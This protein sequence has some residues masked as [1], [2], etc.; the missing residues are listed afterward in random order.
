MERRRVSLGR[1]AFDAFVGAF[2]WLM[3]VMWSGIFVWIFGYSPSTGK[4]IGGLLTL[5]AL[6][7]LAFALVKRS[8]R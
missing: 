7:A 6:T 8:S 4:L 5:C 3:L 2:A 1:N